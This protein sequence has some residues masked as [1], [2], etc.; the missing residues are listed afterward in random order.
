[1]EEKI[2]II[3]DKSQKQDNLIDP[4]EKHEKY[5]KYCH[6]CEKNRVRQRYYK[7]GRDL[8]TCDICN[9]K[10]VKYAFNKHLESLVH[11]RATFSKINT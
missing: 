11:I 2:V 1:M 6:D 10:V 8:V 7:K 4:C 5:E 3:I 9:R